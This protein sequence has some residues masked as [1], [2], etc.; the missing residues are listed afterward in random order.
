MRVCVYGASSDE[1]DVLYKNEIYKLG[2]MMAENKLDLVYGGGA[3]G[4]MGAVARGVQENGG[5]VLGVSPEFFKVDGVLFEKCSNIIYT[6]TMRE[7]KQIMEEE[8]DA[9]IMT[10]GGCGT[11]EE[12]FEI[13]TLKQLQ[14]HNKAI[15]IYN[16]NN[17]YDVLLEMLDRSVTEKFTRGATKLLYYVTDS[18]SDAIDYIVNY[19]P[20]EISIKQLRNVEKDPFIYDQIKNK[21]QI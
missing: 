5:D 12:F 10:P 9:F 21:K 20:V 13:L 7:R 1:I 11:F 3:Q 17:Y 2:K 8:A 19:V 14:R 16:V 6:K 18:P 4:L 15:V